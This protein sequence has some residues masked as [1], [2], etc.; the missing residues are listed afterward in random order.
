MNS[1]IARLKQEFLDSTRQADTERAEIVTESYQRHERL[2]VMLKKAYVFRDILERMSIDIRPDE[3]IVGNQNKNRRGAPFFPEYAIDWIR[4]Q[5]GDLMTRKGDRFFISEGQ[6]AELRALVPY[7]EGRCLRDEVLK[8]LPEDLK[9]I[10][11]LG[12]FG[13]E[14]YTMSGPGHMSPNYTYLLKKGYAALAEECRMKMSQPGAPRDFYEACAISCEALINFAGRY[15]DL[16]ENLAD[17]MGCS[18]DAD[19][20]RQR[21]LREISRICRRVPAAPP[22]GFREALQFIYFCQIAIQLEANGLSIVLGRLDQTLIDY[23]RR[24]I[25]SGELTEDSAM[26]IL[27]CFFL[28]LNEVDKIYSNQA[29]RFLQGPGHGQCITLGGCREDRSDATNE[30][31]YMILDADYEVRLVQPDIALRIHK[32]TP[33]GLLRKATINI[34]A[35]INKIKIFGDDVII[36]AMEDIGID[37]KDAWNFNLLGC[38]EAVIEG[39]TNSWGNSGHVNLAKCLE[40]AL[41]NGV[42][43]LSGARMGPATGNPED[44]SSFD[45]VLAAFKSQVQYFVRHLTEYDNILDAAHADLVPLPFYSTVVEGCLERGI[46]FNRGGAVYNTSCPLGVGP[47]TTGDSL[48]A[49]RKL[50]FDEHRVSLPDLVKALRGD[51]A[52]QEPLRQMLINRAPKFGNDI[53]EVDEVCNTVLRIFCDELRLY[54]NPRGGPFIGALYY[55]SANIP[56]GLKTAASA[57]GRKA[58]QPLNDGGISPNHGM[59]R[60]GPT[61]VAKSVGKLDNMKVPHGCVLNQRFH[62]SVFEGEGKIELFA[63]Y[64]R[65]FIDLGGWECQYNV[66]TTETLKDAQSH[67]EKY[68]DLVVRVAGYS[69]YFTALEKEL[70]DDIINRTEQVHV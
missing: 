15:A 4:D 5:M 24:D 34:R 18:T 50:V 40:L 28:K 26:E 54:T 39:K 33:D 52:D 9:A 65:G 35:G 68:G 55:L 45:A 59:D 42:C 53:D 16:A 37:R 41:N 22:S 23:Y 64:M 49:I 66:V 58:G 1:R 38:S 63:D 12:V 51:F 17:E 20:A 44:F 19:V 25:S 10:H 2:P 60:N 8:R 57:D 48:Y 47:V 13:N 21:E 43:M 32:G 36:R 69:A 30:L 67:P 62:P 3:L 46:E 27:E 14:N 31:S 56:F 61:A 6:K 29:T 70:Q 11:S 7:W